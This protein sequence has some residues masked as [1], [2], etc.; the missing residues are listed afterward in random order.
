[1]HAAFPQRPA[2]RERCRDR[3]RL[4]ADARTGHPPGVIR[5]DALARAGPFVHPRDVGPLR[6]RLLPPLRMSFRARTRAARVLAAL[7]ATALPAAGQ[8]RR[9]PRPAPRAPAARLAAQLDSV[10]EAYERS[11]WPATAARAE[12]VL[13]RLPGDTPPETRFSFTLAAGRAWT[14]MGE[15]A[16]ALP[17]LERALALDAPPRGPR[18]WALAYAGRARFARGD[19]AGARAALQAVEALAPTER[20]RAT[21]A[22]DWRLFGFDSSYARWHTLETPHLHIRLS[23]RAPVLDPRAFA[24]VRERAAVRI[25]AALGDTAAAGAPKRIDVFVWDS[26]LEAAA[27]GLA[28]VHIARPALGL[29]HLTWDQTVGHELA[30]IIAFRAVRPIA[31]API[32]GEGVAVFFDG[33]TDDRLREAAEALSGRGLAG[34]DVRALWRDWSTLPPPLAY[35]VAG[36]VI[37]MLH[38]DGGLP[39]L[40]ALLRTQ[41][42]DDARRIYGPSLDGW[43]DAFESRLAAR[44]RTLSAATSAP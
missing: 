2:T 31:T 4:L 35:P 19:T 3:P 33:S 6:V 39:A 37:D 15:P 44:I 29:T 18:T 41:T 21:V 42:L 13:A 23:P 8:T 38:R 40:R 25:A 43:L 26:D 12:S 16:R 1:M 27:A 14:D 36:A 5:P 10:W 7:A 20:V 17:H 9:A 34:V 22:S 28:R 32:V 30:H 11:D 24:E